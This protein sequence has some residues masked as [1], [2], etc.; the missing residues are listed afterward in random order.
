MKFIYLCAALVI[1]SFT[2]MPI[3]YGVSKERATIL[4][5]NETQQTEEDSISFEEM[6]ALFENDLS[7]EDQMNA[8][9]P[10]AG[11][12]ESFPSGF[13]GANGDSAL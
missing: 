4:A 10:A 2:A 5:S 3:Y 6:Y 9:E 8:I 11:G 1:F 7:V 12:I 13:E